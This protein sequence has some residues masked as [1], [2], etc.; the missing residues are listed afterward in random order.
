MH[1][2][3]EVMSYSPTAMSLIPVRPLSISDIFTST[4]ATYRSRFWLFVLLGVIPSAIALVVFVSG[5]ALLVGGLLPLVISAIDG[6]PSLAGLSAGAVIG[7]LAVL[8]L[9][10]S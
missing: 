3:G 10:P 4:F 1:P 9:G 2:Y 6:N 7:G 8:V 5:V